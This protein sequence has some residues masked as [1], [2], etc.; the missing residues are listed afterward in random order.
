MLQ[1]IQSLFIV[2]SLLLWVLIYFSPLASVY[3]STEI[4]QLKIS[5]L[6]MLTESG[7][8]LIS[9]LLPLMI[10]FISVS[11]IQISAL[12]LYRRRRLQMRFCIYSAISQAGF[13]MLVFYYVYQ[14]SSGESD[15]SVAWNFPVILPVCSAILNLISYRFI[16]KDERLVRSIDRI[17]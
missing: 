9:R 11:I 16:L 4:Y 13:L 10:F 7:T 14:T 15:I 8:E 12:F 1:R 17:R 6:G 2:I 5:G 3:D